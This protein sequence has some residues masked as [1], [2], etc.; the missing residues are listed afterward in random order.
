MGALV[1]AVNVSTNIG[2]EA[3]TNSAGEYYFPNLL[4]GTYRMKAEKTGFQAVIKPDVVLHV[5]DN[6]EINFELAN[7]SASESITVD[8]GEPLLQL[9]TSDLRAVVDAKTTRELPLNGRSWTD[10]AILQPG[11]A[12][13]ETQA[14]YAAAADRGNRGFGSHVSISGGRVR[15]NSYRIDGVSVNDYSNGGPG[16]VLG[17]TLGVDAIEE[18]SVLTANTPAEYGRTSAGVI[19]AITRSGTNDLHGSAYEFFRNSA[20]DAR[21]YFDG[22]SIPP[23]KRNQFGAAIGG[24]FGRITRSSS[25]TTKG[26]DSPRES[27]IP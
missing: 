26:T 12:A 5:Q 27:R 6:V 8:D 16:S 15:Q 13:V 25:S 20:L 19:S 10:L 14:S 23:F 22:A 24:P 3:I 11:V 21:N 18:F 1:L 7:G 4:P 9:A 17:G 2:H